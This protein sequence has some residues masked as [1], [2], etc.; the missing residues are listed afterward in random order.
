[1]DKVIKLLPSMAVDR[2]S[3]SR[4]NDGKNWSSKMTI[5]YFWLVTTIFLACG[6]NYTVNLY[7]VYKHQLAKYLVDQELYGKTVEV[8]Q[9]GRKLSIKLNG[10][11]VPEGQF[12]AIIFSSLEE[13]QSCR[14]TLTNIKTIADT[15]E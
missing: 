8:R 6:I 14:A 2:P 3:V 10:E 7:G 1:M 12:N 13:L 11:L 5:R 4:A 9:D 15:Q